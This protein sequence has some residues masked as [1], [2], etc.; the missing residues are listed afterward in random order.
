MSADP[1][2]TPEFFTE[3]H[4]AMAALDGYR[5]V[6]ETDPKRPS[7]HAYGLHKSAFL[8]SDYRKRTG[9]GCVDVTPHEVIDCLVQAKIKNWLLMG[10]HGMV[11]YLPMPRATQDVDVMVPFSQKQKAAKAIAATWPMLT[12]VDL[13]QVVRFIDATDLDTDG[14]GKPVI[15]LMLPWGKF[16]ETILQKHFVIDEATGSRYPTVEAVLTSKYAALVSPHR[17]RDKKEQDVA[18]FRRV[19]NANHESIDHNILL[20]LGNEV[21]EKGGSELVRFVQLCLDNQPLPV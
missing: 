5:G 20:A 10:L 12:R 4:A 21:W 13:P 3:R 8:T 6:D 11:G 19:V 15:D 9:R 14:N 18:D 16:Q 2:F 17:S 1:F 7:G